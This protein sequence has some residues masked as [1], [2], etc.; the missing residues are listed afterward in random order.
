MMR[1]AVGGSKINLLI[2]GE[3]FRNV[4]TQASFKRT[5]CSA[6][7]PSAGAGTSA[8][9]P[10]R[11]GPES[12]SRVLPVEHRSDYCAALVAPVMS[13]TSLTKVASRL[14]LIVYFLLYGTTI[15]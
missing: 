14:L 10:T 11:P 8:V 6:L 5:W 13:R 4:F 12:P 3:N 9:N 1:I 2:Q 15:E 7:A